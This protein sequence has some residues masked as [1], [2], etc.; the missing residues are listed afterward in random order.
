M[1]ETSAF[2]GFDGKKKDGSPFRFLIVDDSPF[3]VKQME[4]FVEAIQC[5]VAGTAI[6]GKEALRVYP[7]VKPDIVTL[8]ITMPEMD[9]LETLVELMKI[10]PKTRVIMVSALGHENMVKESILRG[11]TYFI[12]KPLTLSKV[13]ETLIPVLRKIA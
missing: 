6:N 4:R 3:M 8:D 1:S 10:D 2:D 11:A 7:R 9:G 13:K 5:Q 12:V